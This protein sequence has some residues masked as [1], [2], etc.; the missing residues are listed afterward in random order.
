MLPTPCL[1]NNFNTTQLPTLMTLESPQKVTFTNMYSMQTERC[2]PS[3]PTRFR[4]SSV[5]LCFIYARATDKTGTFEGWIPA[6]VGNFTDAMC[7]TVNKRD[8]HPYFMWSCPGELGL[9]RVQAAGQGERFAALLMCSNCSGIL[10]VRMGRHRMLAGGGGPHG[11]DSV[12]VWNGVVWGSCFDSHLK[13]KTSKFVTVTGAVCMC[14]TC[15]M[16]ALHI[17]NILA[18]RMY[19]G[20]LCMLLQSAVHMCR[21]CLPNTHMHEQ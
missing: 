17:P 10:S 21:L 3:N 11:A 20:K 6:A 19:T 9:V 1:Q 14:Y 5:E 12:G 8:A 15:Q 4:M 16:C 7:G 18:S 2:D 13:S